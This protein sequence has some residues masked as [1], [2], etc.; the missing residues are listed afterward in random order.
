MRL[1]TL[2]QAISRTSVTRTPSTAS[3]CRLPRCTSDR[4][5][6]AGSSA[7]FSC[8]KRSTSWGGMSVKVLRALLQE[9]GQHGLQAVAQRLASATPG[10]RH[11]Q[12]RN[13]VASSLVTGGAIIVGTKMSM[14]VPGSTPVKRGSTTPTIS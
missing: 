14:K 12:V 11:S 7:A 6:D 5:A 9:A 13:H 3:A 10:F 4:P 1:A 2:A 8:T